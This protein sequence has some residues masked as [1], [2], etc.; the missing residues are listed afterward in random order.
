MEYLVMYA[1][2]DASFIDLRDFL[3]NGEVKETLE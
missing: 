3:V 1:A 2:D